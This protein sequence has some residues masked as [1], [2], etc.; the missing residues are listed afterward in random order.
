MSGVGEAS[1]VLGLVSSI[2]A[3]I[4]AVSEIYDAYDNVQ[5]LPKQ[6]RD[7]AEKIPLIHHTLSLAETNIQA[8]GISE[9][10][11]R[12]AKP[13]LEQCKKDVEGFQAISK[14]CLPAN[15]A[16]RTE[17]MQKAMQMKMKASTLKD[18]MASLVTN[19]ALLA[20]CQIFQDTATL[21]DIKAAVDQLN[22]ADDE[23]NSVQVTHHGSGSVNALT[24]PGHQENNN[25]SGSGNFYK[26]EHQYFGST[27]GTKTI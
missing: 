3:I 6:V 12:S 15:D 17:R 25:N 26:G 22:T 18:Y 4:E 5:G 2:I 14:K 20:D 23:L 1:L 27:S 13:I 8:K 7:A 11:L 24:G 21:Q 16:T 9:D 19:L 10:A